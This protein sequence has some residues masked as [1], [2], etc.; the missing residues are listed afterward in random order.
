MARR[1]RTTDQSTPMFRPFGELSRLSL[2]VRVGSR[3]A[4]M[5]YFGYLGAQ[6]WRN[7][8]HTHSFFEICYSL[9]GS[10][11]FRLNGQEHAV[12]RGDLFVARPGE[13][14]EIVSARRDVLK[15]VFWAFT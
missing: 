3:R 14:H 4:D 5:L 9:D 7:Y 10:G 12:G 8:L 11:V 6:W 1:A 15:I 2:S 13:A